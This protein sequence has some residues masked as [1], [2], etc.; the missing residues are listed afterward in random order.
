MPVKQV[1]GIVAKNLSS[2][3]EIP[4]NYIQVIGNVKN[5]LSGIHAEE[6]LHNENLEAL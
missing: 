6:C 1:N 2:V 3:S 5:T 4:S